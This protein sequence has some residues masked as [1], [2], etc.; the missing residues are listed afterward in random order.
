MYVWCVPCVYIQRPEDTRCPT[1]KLLLSAYRLETGWGGLIKP[2]AGLDSFGS[3]GDPP[4][5]TETLESP[6]CTAM[7][8]FTMTLGFQ[9]QVLVLNQETR[10]LTH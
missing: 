7:L 9:A 5:T 2:G 1:I 3:Y 10:A 4:V 6:V 8:G